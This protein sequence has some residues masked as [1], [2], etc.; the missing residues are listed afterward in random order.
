MKLRERWVPLL[1]TVL[2]VILCTALPFLW[3]AARDRQLDASCWRAD[4]ASDF[5]SAAGRENAVAREL[6][7]WRQQPTEALPYVQPTESVTARQEVQP[8]LAALRTAG[9]L[10]ESFLNAADELVTQ[11]TQCLSSDLESNQ[12]SYYFSDENSRNLTLTVSQYGTLTAVNGDL[13]L[14]DGFV[15]ADVAAAYCTMLGLD[16]FTDWEDA[17][18]LGYGAPAPYYS[19]DAQ[20]YLVANIDRGYFSMSV[21]SMAPY[22]YAGL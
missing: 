5:L 10:P 2:L 16:S 11:A 19:A 1:G 8:Y 3:F 22:A 12:I 13:G 6:Y 4:P 21:T 7:F 18:P 15:P 20:L 17:E 9:V 14:Q